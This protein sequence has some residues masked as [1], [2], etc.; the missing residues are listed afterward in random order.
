MN[1]NGQ[2]FDWREPEGIRWGCLSRVFALL[3]LSQLFPFRHTALS[4]LT[5]RDECSYSVQLMP[6]TAVSL[7]ISPPRTAYS[8]PAR[9]SHKNRLDLDQPP[10]SSS[11]ALLAYNLCPEAR[12]FPSRDPPTPSYPLFLNIQHASTPQLTTSPLVAPAPQRFTL[13][14]RVL[15]LIQ[16][17]P[18]RQKYPLGSEAGESAEIFDSTF[19]VVRGAAAGSRSLATAAQ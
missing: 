7:P 16:F 5:F 12:L 2:G 8:T 19:A 4:T 18:R 15:H 17:R 3:D 13:Q 6:K 11:R 14:F 1:P 10:N 9:I